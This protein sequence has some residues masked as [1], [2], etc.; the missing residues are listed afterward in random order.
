MGPTSS[1]EATVVVFGA[2]DGSATWPTDSAETP[3]RFRPSAQ[4]ST[5]G[6]HG[7]G[8]PAVDDPTVADAF[9]VT[10][11]D[12]LREVRELD[13]S[14]PVVGL[15]DDPSGPVAT[16]PTVDAIATDSA[17][18]D[19][20]VARLLARGDDPIRRSP[21][22][23]PPRIERLQTGT[24][25]LATVRSDEEAYRTAVAVADEVFPAYDAAIGVVESDW[26][27]PVAVSSDVDRG[28]CRRVRVGHG[29]AG[30]ALKLSESI[31]TP[32]RTSGEQIT[33]PVGDEA[34]LQISTD[35]PDEV[36]RDDARL[37]ELLASHLEETLDRIRA[38]E[39]LRAERDRLLALFENVPDPAIA[40]DFV[41]GV[42]L[43]R[44]VNSAFEETF[45][46]DADRV[47]GECID[48]FILPSSEEAHSEAD[49]LNKKLQRGESVRKAVTRRTVDGDRHFI[50]HVIPIHLDAENVAGYAIYTD[51]TER[52][53]REAT[54]R[55]QNERLEQFSS[56][57]SHDL[58]NPLSVA[59]GY[60]DLTRET[61][62][63]GH[64]DR[65]DESLDRMERLIEDLLSLAREGEVVG[66]TERLSLASLA[67]DAWAGVDTGDA[68]LVVDE[69]VMI[70]ANRN[71][72]CA[73]LENLFRNSVEH[74]PADDQLDSDRPIT[75][76]IGRMDACDGSERGFYVADDGSGLPEESDRLFETG[77]TTDEDGTGLG[78][79][80][81]RRIADAHGWEVRATSAADGG[82]RFEFHTD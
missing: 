30:T 5:D 66:D 12:G 1:R 81:T 56:I 49:D 14:R 70:D 74:G 37:A 8:D 53:E 76:R 15:V 80:I 20:Q 11:I 21:T 31:V 13:A 69:D 9:V 48:E 73:L 35:D 62:N 42:P 47:A 44:R 65:V 33:V 34:V 77:Y 75:V 17:A 64:L 18:V 22:A 27:E 61:G 63:I 45:G 16:D 3:V 71:R 60:V 58:R 25:R 6:A 39:E 51:V 23:D 28:D 29:S 79:S 2:D 52:E 57:V 26:I 78:L 38:D 24:A 68:E 7:P 4:H 50:L 43:F 19:A 67:Q 72:T 10:D 36:C 41:D 40:Y 55:R 54:L 59:K 82:A 46:Y 32:G